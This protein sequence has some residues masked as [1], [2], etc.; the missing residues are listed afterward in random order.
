MGIVSRGGV[1]T[2]RAVGRYTYAADAPMVHDE[3]VYDLASL[4]KVVATTAMAML[5]V[6]R[7]ALNLGSPVAD[8][9][10]QFAVEDPRKR[11]VTM[12]MLLA[13]NSGLPGYVRLFEQVSSAEELL[14]AAIEMPLEYD[15]LT[16]AEYS[17]IG[18]IALGAALEMIAGE[19]I[20]GFCEREIFGPLQ[21]TNTRFLPP[22]ELRTH[23]PPTENDQTFRKRVI[24]GEVHDENASLLGGIAGHAG[25]FSNA[26]DI[27]RFAQ[28][29]LRAGR[30]QG[31][32]FRQSTVRMFTRRIAQPEDTSRALG[33]DTPSQP[34][35]SGHYFSE[36]SFG[37]L[38]FTGTS[39]W[40][41]PER[42]L[43]VVLLTNR[44]WPDRNNQ[45]I[46][47]IRPLFHDAVAENL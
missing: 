37:H 1:I 36:D 21:M 19:S 31:S 13:H 29:L 8:I 24:Q 28:E 14:Y 40:I 4:T 42:Q 10:P 18:F 32:L 12:R 45:A 7:G 3:T 15:P 39:L 2:S 35:Q 22:E 5:L 43:A 44:T 17:D 16:R 20:A 11:R 33:W 9:L 41:D 26:P 34:S 38:G 27:A 23:I 25:L 6:D 47:E 30:G 46:K